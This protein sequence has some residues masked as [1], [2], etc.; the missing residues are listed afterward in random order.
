MDGTV[1]RNAG[2]V[3]GALLAALLV[4]AG[5]A[6]GSVALPDGLVVTGDVE[7]HDTTLQVTGEL[8][9]AAGGSLSLEGVLVVIAPDARGV[10]RLVVEPGAALSMRDSTVTASSAAPADAI[11]VG[12]HGAADVRGSTF[13]GL[14]PLAAFPPSP[15]RV[16]NGFVVPASGLLVTSDQVLLQDTTVV[17]ASGCGVSVVSSS[18]RLEGVAIREVRPAVAAGRAYAAGV[19]VDG[20]SPSLSGIGLRGA[21]AL[22]G[23]GVSGAW[24]AGIVAVETSGLYIGQMDA[25]GMLAE[26]SARPESSAALLLTR[27]GG[28]VVEGGSISDGQDGVV[29]Y[30]APGGEPLSVSGLT[31]RAMSDTPIIIPAQ[32]YTIATQFSFENMTIDVCGAN[33]V[34]FVSDGSTAQVSF[35]LYNVSV[36]NCS[37]AGVLLHARNT[38]A[39]SIH[40][41]TIISCNA[42][43]NGLEGFY[44]R[45][46]NVAAAL[47]PL[48]AS[49]TASHNNQSGFR[50]SNVYPGGS[51]AIATARFDDNA[52]INNSADNT[53]FQNSGGFVLELG[54]PNTLALRYNNNTALGNVPV[55]PTAASHWGH[56]IQVN[57]RS[58]LV[59]S[60]SFMS[61][62]TAIENGEYGMW[63]IG[64]TSPTGRFEQAKLRDSVIR[65]QEVGIRAQNARVEVWNSV[66]D[67]PLEFEGV[68]TDFVIVGTV[69]NRLAGTTTGVKTIHSYKAVDITAVWQNDRPVQNTSLRFINGSGSSAAVFQSVTPPTLA[70]SLITNA[71]GRWTG[72]VYDW[73]FDRDLPA[74]QN[75]KA[76]FAPLTVAVVPQAVESRADPFDMYANIV[77]QV[78]FR[79]DGPPVIIVQTPRDN[80]VYT[81]LN[82]NVSGIVTDDISG[83][84]GLQVSLDGSNWTDVNRSG[85][86]YS[87]RL[88]GLTDGTFDIHLRAWDRANDGLVA[89]NYSLVV[90]YAVR[91]D[92]EPPLLELVL[93]E[94]HDG[95]VYYTNQPVMV[96]QGAVDASIVALFVNGI[97]IVPT[98][99]YFSVAPELTSEGPQTFVF[100]ALDAAGNTRTITVTVVRDTF[101]PTLIIDSHDVSS[102]LYWNSNVILLAGI[103]DAN[104][105]VSVGGTNVTV[106]S[107]RW[108]VP[109]TLQSGRNAIRIFAQD[110]AGNTAERTVVVHS[111]T[112][113]PGVTI[114]SLSEG[115][116]VNSTRV[117][118]AG[119]VD[120][121]VAF[122]TIGLFVVPVASGAFTATVGLLDGPNEITVRAVDRAG[123]AGTATVNIVVDTVAP[124]ITFLGLP[125]GLTVS[126]FRVIVRGSV[127]EPVTLAVNGVDVSLAGL[128][129]DT[130]VDL[131]EGEN[132]IRVRAVDAAGNEFLVD[133]VVVL[134]T[135]APPITVTTPAA[136]ATVHD[137]L[138]RVVGKTEPFA[139]VLVGG[140]LIPADENGDFVAYV[141]LP[142]QGSNIVVLEVQDGAGNRASQS[143]TVLL[144]PAEVDTTGPLIASA[145]VAG[146]LAVGLGVAGLLL[147]RRMVG[148][149]VRAYE[150]AQPAPPVPDAA[151]GSPRLPRAPRPPRPPT[152]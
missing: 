60:G 143:M 129:F 29:V 67:N 109:Y 40:D 52:A 96:F 24:V 124:S 43:Y 13:Y 91:I 107:G 142:A 30:G 33:G 136:G 35:R 65:G 8:R 53:S 42:T 36:S 100:L 144:T 37:G 28:V 9:V 47:N 15:L 20:G 11:S 12:L 132:S 90:L 145:G 16:E 14:A 56:A 82:L 148:R 69:H 113:P 151:G 119:T 34:S 70:T 104:T 77:G 44:I 131:A 122:V 93:P 94:L 83:V 26:G 89:P 99:S 49:S 63:L 108:V 138:L 105:N 4:A 38:G 39:A 1:P 130:P 121:N 58:S 133:K 76:D 103:T 71:Q 115:Q 3:A 80:G 128:D 21:F 147:A 101:N 23:E 6:A 137:A 134:D 22:P 120:E 135:E 117:V 66:M 126:N 73:I 31:I 149:K 41:F 150:A 79:D 87:H 62:N 25:R 55:P 32:A 2:L 78:V 45:G 140:H 110:A 85:G 54:S 68:E 111:D 18:A 57:V 112:V 75:Q 139:T 48:V 59:I 51:T 97:P 127:S 152:V 102:E 106:A 146:A 114:D 88:G 5:G 141:R 74:S 7:F 61:G 17:S 64:G 84:A 92:T 123:N 10:A 19:C 72:W 81:T 27:A 98:G 118:I 46:E 86:L 95:D 125:D 116:R 50:V